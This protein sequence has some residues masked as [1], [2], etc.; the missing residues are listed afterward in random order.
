MNGLTVKNLRILILSHEYPPYIFGGIATFTN[1]FA[2]FLANNGCHVKVISGRSK[3]RSRII[4]E[5]RGK[6]MIYRTYFPDIPIRQL[7][8]S[9]FNGGII[10]KAVAESDII[11][12]HGFTVSFI[13]D[14]LKRYEKSI[15]TFFHGSPLALVVGFRYRVIKNLGELVYCSE[16]PLVIAALKKDVESSTHVLFVAKHVQQEFTWFYPD[17]TSKILRGDVV[18]PGVDISLVDKY[19]CLRQER[20]GED[21]TIA[22]VGRLYTTKGVT[23]AI[24]AIRVIIGEYG[25]RNARLWIFGDGPLRDYIMKT[26]K[27]NNLTEKVKLFG[28]VPRDKLFELMSKYV[29]VLLHP[30]LYE[31]APM[32]LIEA[33]ALGIPVVTF[34]LPWAEEFVVNGVNGYR[35]PAFDVLALSEATLKAQNLRTDFIRKFSLKFDKQHNL[36]RILS[37]LHNLVS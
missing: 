29:D 34:N 8:Y 9:L 3:E 22:Y 30:S 31:G 14:I 23:Y 32:A 18:Y 37:I 21:L 6:I 15:V 33:N 19:R 4:S 28:S 10:E 12:T 35:V 36:E 5:E 11:I 1:E 13:L 7:W 27:R 25:Y 16:L 26:V 2:E 20:R 17:L 24:D